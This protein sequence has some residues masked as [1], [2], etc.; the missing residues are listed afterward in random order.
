MQDIVRTHREAL[1]ENFSAWADAVE[2][3]LLEAD[4]HLLKQPDRRELAGLVLTPRVGR[5]AGAHAPG[6]RLL[7]SRGTAIT[8]VFRLS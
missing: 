2:Q 5:D 3:C 7:R 1:A 8:D 6:R 4:L